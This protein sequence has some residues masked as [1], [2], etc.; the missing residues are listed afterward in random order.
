M[1]REALRDGAYYAR[2][3]DG[4]LYR[5]GTIEPGR[6]VTVDDVLRSEAVGDHHGLVFVD[7]LDQ[8]P[9]RADNLGELTVRTNYAEGVF[10]LNAH[11]TFAPGGAGKSVPSLSPPPDAQAPDEA[12][13]PVQLERIHLRGVL[14]TPG[15]VTVEGQPRVHGAVVAGGQITPTAG[16][17]DRLEVWYDDDLRR[18]LIR[19]VPL[20]HQAPGTWSEKY[21]ERRG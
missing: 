9:P 14:V 2:G 6:G 13:V 19:G 17:L 18:G 3:Q 8:T 5:H 10:V 12:R 4:L 15:D 20:V 16:S 21:G 11:V 1:K 7:T